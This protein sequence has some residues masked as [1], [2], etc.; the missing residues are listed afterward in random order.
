[1]ALTP[2]K[3]KAIAAAGAAFHH[4]EL[5][6]MAEARERFADIGVK[7]AKEAGRAA[8]GEGYVI[9]TD[10]FWYA[11]LIAALARGVVRNETRDSFTKQLSHMTLREIAKMAD[12]DPSFYDT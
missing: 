3:K 8:R 2:A 4:A 1:M 11:W 10:N 12:T 6:R 7:H 5:Q 9:P